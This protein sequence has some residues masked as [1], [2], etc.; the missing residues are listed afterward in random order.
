[1][2]LINQTKGIL[3]VQFESRL[4]P[5]PYPLQTLCVYALVLIMCQLNTRACQL[6]RFLYETSGPYIWQG[7]NLLNNSRLNNY[8][9][10]IYRQ[11]CSNETL[12]FQHGLY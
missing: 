5:G 7:Y 1:M 11:D 10:P 2:E 6:L 8:A 3:E 9:Q 4:C 12:K